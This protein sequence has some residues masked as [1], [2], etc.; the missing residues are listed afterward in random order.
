MDIS[1]ILTTEI[2]TSLMVREKSN[3]SQL[4]KDYVNNNVVQKGYRCLPRGFLEILTFL[5]SEMQN[6]N[7]FQHFTGYDT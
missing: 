1:L 6:A 4:W 5:F 3:Y 2:S 7:S